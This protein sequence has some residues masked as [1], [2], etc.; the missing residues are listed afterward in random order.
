MLSG[1][2]GI[3]FRKNELFAVADISVSPVFTMRSPG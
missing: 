1:Q 3:V 2:C